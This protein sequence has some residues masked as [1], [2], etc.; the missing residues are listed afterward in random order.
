MRK[1]F[2][3][4]FSHKMRQNLGEKKGMLRSDKIMPKNKQI[5]N[6]IDKKE[7]DAK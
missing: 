5:K 1:V 3:I 7:D 6:M 4:A 2:L